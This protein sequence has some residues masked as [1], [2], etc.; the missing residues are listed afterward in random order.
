MQLYRA[1][2]IYPVSSSPFTDGIIAIEGER[3]IAVG[4]TQEITQQYPDTPITDLGA[5]MLLPQAVNAHTHLELMPLAHLGTQHIAEHSFVQWIRG[6]VK[7]WRTIPVEI[8]VAGARDGC[9]MLMESGTAVV[10]DISN[11]HVSLEPLLESG[12]YGILYHE[13][14]SPN[15]TEAPRLLQK[16]QEQIRRWRSEYGEERIRFGVTL[17]TPFTVSAE[18]F[19]MVV[20]WVLDEH[21][22]LCIHAAECLAETE[23]LLYGTGEIADNLFPAPI[24][25]PDLIVPPGIS[26][27]AYL[28]ELGIL[29]TRPLLAHGV[30]VDFNDLRLLVEQQITVA[31]CPRSNFLLNCGRMPIEA[32]QAAGVPVA[33][34]TDSLASSPSL[35]IW[36]EAVSAAK[37]HLAAG[38][39]IDASDLLRYCTLDGA[40]A[41][42]FDAILGSLEPGKLAR[43]AVGRMQETGDNVLDCPHTANEMLQMLW[44]GQVTVKAK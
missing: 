1:Q 12:L 2:Y 4:P 35:S 13:V 34:G 19:R 27:I 26:P 25:L 16:A 22:P 15:P 20:P 36:E 11:T 10:A 43:L 17:H 44:D 28:H 9:R 5:A 38:T 8:Q 39:N 6:L 31:H 18:M 3:I 37:I 30:Q 24:R 29:A 21:V 41:L 23:F 7:T 14:I 42:G 40:R 32:Y 33:M